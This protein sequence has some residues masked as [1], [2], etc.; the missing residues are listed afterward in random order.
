MSPPV[1]YAP[2]EV[3]FAF[4]DEIVDGAADGF[5]RQQSSRAVQ[6]AR[7]RGALAARLLQ[8]EPDLVGLQRLS[9]D[10]G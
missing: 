10:A 4:V 9:R 7:R 6:D 1:L 5:G 2:A 8:T 3:V